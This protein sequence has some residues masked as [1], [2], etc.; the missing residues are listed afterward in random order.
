MKFL[1]CN[2]NQP[3]EVG[4]IIPII[5]MRAVKV[6]EVR[7]VVLS[8][9]MVGEQCQNQNSRLGL[10]TKI[11]GPFPVLPQS[12]GTCFCQSQL[13]LLRTLVGSLLAGSVYP[14]NK[15]WLQHCQTMLLPRPM[16]W[17]LFVR[18]G[19]SSRCLDFRVSPELCQSLQGFSCVFPILPFITLSHLLA[20]LVFWTLL[21]KQTQMKEKEPGCG[22]RGTWVSAPAPSHMIRAPHSVEQ[23]PLPL[24]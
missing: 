9:R 6:C 1:I 12:L 4:I 21:C 20:A 22:V 5:Q 2:S 18:K 23:S 14:Q 10:L 16:C 24:W 17:R 8:P 19:L 3:C 13:R 7:G 15:W 11:F